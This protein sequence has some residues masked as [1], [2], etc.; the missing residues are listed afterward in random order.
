MHVDPRPQ[1]PQE[2]LDAEVLPLD[3]D[4]QRDR[5]VRAGRA[6]LGLGGDRD[7]RDPGRGRVGAQLVEHPGDVRRVGHRQ[8]ER[9][10]VYLPRGRGGR[11][12][13]C[14]GDLG[15]SPLDLRVQVPRTR[16]LGRDQH[17]PRGRGPHEREAE[18][19][20][21]DEGLARAPHRSSESE[22]DRRH[23]CTPALRMD[24]PTLNLYTVRRSSSLRS[25]ETRETPVSHGTSAR[26]RISR[27]TDGWEYV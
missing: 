24:A 1:P 27:A 19:G 6:R 3:D 20:T 5:P 23:D 13:A 12:R 2:A 16:V 22:R 14:R 17:E 9:L 26:R 10:R 18:Q 7:E 15:L 8:L 21:R 11:R 25:L 4:R